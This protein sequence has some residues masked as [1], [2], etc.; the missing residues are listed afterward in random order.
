MKRSVL[1]VDDER[2]FRVMAEEAL[3]R[4]GFEVKTAATLTKARAELEHF[5]PDV[6]VLDRRLPDGDGLDLLQAAREQGGATALVIVVTAYGDVE[7]AVHALRAG[8]SDYL[9]KP[10][11]LPDLLVKLNKA[12]EARGLRDQLALAKSSAPR[13]PITRCDSPAERTLRS[14][15]ESVAQSPLTPVLLVGPSGAGKQCAA[16]L[17]HAMTYAS[18]QAPF[19]EV[20]CAA[21]PRD[22]FES[23]LFGHEKGAFTDARAPR[24]GLIELAD[25]GTLFLDEVTEL[26]EGSQAK[27]LKFLDTMRFRRVGGQREMEVRLRV[28]A[29]TNQDAARLVEEGKL[30]ADLYHRLSVFTIELP[31]LKRAAR[32]HRRAGR[33]LRTL[34]RRSRE[35]ARERHLR[36][37]RSQLLLSYD[38]PGNIRELRNIIERAV[39]LARGPELTEKDIVLPRPAGS[40]AP[41]RPNAADAFFAIELHDQA[42]PPLEQIEKSYVARVLEHFGGQAHASRAELG[43]F[44]SDV[45][46]AAARSGVGLGIAVHGSRD[47]GSRFAVRGSRFAVRGSRFTDHGSRITVHGSRITV[48]GSRFTD[49]GSR[50]TVHGS[51]F[52]DHGSRCANCDV[53][54]VPLFCEGAAV[55]ARVNPELAALVRLRRR[56]D[57]RC[58]RQRW[59][60]V[61]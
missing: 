42:P 46:E 59:G 35:E 47:H 58:A 55:L 15:L 41:A 3:A 56:V 10:I 17:L 6:I 11:Q 1:V 16:E 26:A 22:L 36:A 38:Y 30:R 53:G 50:I 33:R 23:E 7:N 40:E 25:G 24:R 27:L 20:N 60:W 5:T 19:V 14:R 44:V 2:V 39:I 51:R 18:A 37:A 43:D 45:F 49:H 9:T 12:L 31:A 54:A 21:V 48:H 61:E 32:G 28:V 8:A 57:T 13:P 34:F 4:E 29:A 52:T